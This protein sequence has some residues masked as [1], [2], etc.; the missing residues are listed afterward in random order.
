MG[1]NKEQALQKTINKFTNLID[2]KVNSNVSVA[3]I[4]KYY[5][6]QLGIISSQEQ[7]N[8]PTSNI[9]QC[10]FEEDIKQIER[11]QDDYYEEFGI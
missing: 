7:I 10:F 6:I 8:M 5:E 2:G 3:T 11:E 4:I 9:T 1:T